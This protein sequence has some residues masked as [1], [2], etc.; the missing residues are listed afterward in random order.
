MQKEVV[1][2]RKRGREE[3]VLPAESSVENPNSYKAT[4]DEKRRMLDRVSFA[5]RAIDKL[6]G[7]GK[8]QW[9]RLRA[10][11]STAAESRNDLLTGIRLQMPITQSF[12]LDFV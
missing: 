9:Y 4:A 6:L 11:F 8:Q 3:V 12:E 2:A 5:T 10:Y 1:Q 7:Q